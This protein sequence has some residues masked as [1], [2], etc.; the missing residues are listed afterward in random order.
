MQIS[1]ICLTINFLAACLLMLPLGEGGP[2]I[3]NT[4]TSALNVALLL[5]A[6]RKKLGRLEMNP[7]RQT[8]RTLTLAALAAGL[9]AWGGWFWWEKTIGHASLALKLGAVFVPAGIA[10]GIYWII[11]L[12]CHVPAAREMT[13]FALARFKR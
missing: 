3:A 13:A 6:L 12:L 7:L 1:L 4:C 10:G 2:G 5:F 11:A 8:L 9:I